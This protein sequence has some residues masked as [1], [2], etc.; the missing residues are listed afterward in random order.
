MN[1]LRDTHRAL[2][3]EGELLDFH[4]KWPP[5]ARVVAR[6]ET[7]GRLAEPEF[8]AQLR[9]ADAGMR[10]ALRIGLF[11]RIATRTREIREHYD[12]ADELIEAWDDVVDA[13]LERRLRA[14]RGPVDVVEKVV[15][16]LYRV[17]PRP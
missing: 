6:G 11:R 4:P 8:P 2:G 5:W 16:R 9:A 3:P 15:F 17:T 13:G 14:T 1:V 12:D 7:L 10:E